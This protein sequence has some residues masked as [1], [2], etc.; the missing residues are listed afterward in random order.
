MRRIIAAGTLAVLGTFAV[1]GPA[2]ALNDVGGGGSTCREWRTYST[3]APS[4]YTT[5]TCVRWW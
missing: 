4:F 1:A 3:G 5:R 2:S